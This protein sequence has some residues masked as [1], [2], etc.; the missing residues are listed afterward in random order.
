MHYCLSVW[1]DAH[2]ES[3]LNFHLDDL[4]ALLCTIKLHK[5]TCKHHCTQLMCTTCRPT[6]CELRPTTSLSL[7]RLSHMTASSSVM[8]VFASHLTTCQSPQLAILVSLMMMMMMSYSPSRTSA[9][10]WTMSLQCLQS[11]TACS[12]SPADSDIVE[13][14]VSWPTSASVAMCS[15]DDN[16]S[17]QIVSF[18]P[19][20]VT[21]SIA[22]CF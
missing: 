2:P 13:P 19:H 16:V 18:L 11:L 20:D 3:C 5:T 21:K 14:W 6:L 1:N 22:V 8:W 12:N 4:T 17:F 10:Q 9:A 7:Y 15:A